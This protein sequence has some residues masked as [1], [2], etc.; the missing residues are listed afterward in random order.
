MPDT[1]NVIAGEQTPLTVGAGQTVNGY[2]ATIQAVPS[3]VSFHVV[4]VAA[5]NVFSDPE[6]LA[7]AIDGIAS[8][9]SGYVNH[10]VTVPGVVSLGSFQD[11][12]NNQNSVT[13]WDV[14]VASNVNPAVTAEQTLVFTDA[15]PARFEAKVAAIQ[16]S[17]DTFAAAPTLNVG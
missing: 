12:D 6:L 11:L 16:A 7:A 14:L 13:F 3:G 4:F 15:I 9:Y 1:Y 8:P 17:L 2:D 10:D 5:D